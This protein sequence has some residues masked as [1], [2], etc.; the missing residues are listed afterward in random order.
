MD[1]VN[2]GDLSRLRAGK[3]KRYDQIRVI[4]SAEGLTVKDA[5]GGNMQTLGVDIGL[6]PGLPPVMVVRLAAGAFDVQGVAQYLAFDPET[7]APRAV[8]R[9]EWADG[10]AIDFPLPP[11]P[12]QAAADASPPPPPA[13][14]PAGEPAPSGPE[15][16]TQGPSRDHG[17]DGT[18]L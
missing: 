10:T 4:A 11:P 12:A 5:L 15:K 6:R 3:P 9:I 7:N 13:E 17:D 1:H 16:G 2:G 14:Q 18:P 8:R